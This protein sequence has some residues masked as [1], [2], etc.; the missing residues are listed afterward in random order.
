MEIY[1]L[2]IIHYLCHNNHIGIHHDNCVIAIIC[3]GINS[4]LG[5]TVVSFSNFA[6]IASVYLAA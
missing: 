1:E 5:V 6:H 4:Q 2:S 3:W